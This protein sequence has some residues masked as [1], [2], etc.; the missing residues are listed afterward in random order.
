[1]LA[2]PFIRAGGPPR[3]PALAFIVGAFLI[4]GEIIT[5]QVC[6]ARSATSLFLGAAFYSRGRS[7]RGDKSRIRFVE[8]RR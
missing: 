3:W 1:M 5:A 8:Y 2:V 7:C 4:A 6:S